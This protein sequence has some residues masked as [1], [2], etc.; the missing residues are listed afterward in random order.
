LLKQSGF[1]VIQQSE[2]LLPPQPF[3]SARDTGGAFLVGSGHPGTRSR[4][5]NRSDPLAYELAIFILGNR[6]SWKAE[7]SSFLQH[8]K[9]KLSTVPKLIE[10][11]LLSIFNQMETCGIRFP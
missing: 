5:L 9:R 2:H 4:N 11:G 8:M 6:I 10:A 1:A 7:I 3:L